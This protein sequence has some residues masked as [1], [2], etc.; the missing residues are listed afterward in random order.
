M[1]VDLTIG[2]MARVERMIRE[3]DPEDAVA[4]YDLGQ[5]N[6][7]P[8]PEG[9]ARTSHENLVILKDLV[10]SGKLKPVIDRKYLLAETPEALRYTENGHARGNVVVTL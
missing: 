10:E 5:L 9:L 1:N 2:Q 8:E 4:L 3:L 6:E 7:V